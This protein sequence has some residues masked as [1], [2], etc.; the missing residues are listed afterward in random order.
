M[1]FRAF[2]ILPIAFSQAVYTVFLTAVSFT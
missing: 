2:Y 1:L